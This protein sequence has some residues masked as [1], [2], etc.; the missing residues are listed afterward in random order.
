M[1]YALPIRH[2]LESESFE[3]DEVTDVATADY[4]VVRNTWYRMTLNSV[5][6]PGTPVSDPDQPIIPNPEPDEKSLG[7]EVEIIPW[8]IVD[9]EVPTL[10]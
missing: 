9:I 3:G 5:Q 2:N 4:G 7:V 6:K 10:H 8:A 1:Y